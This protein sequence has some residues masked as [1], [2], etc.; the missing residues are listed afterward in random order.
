MHATDNVSEFELSPCTCDEASVVQILRTP[1]HFAAQNGNHEL[2]Q[3]LLQ[4][5]AD[6][7]AVDQANASEIVSSVLTIIVWY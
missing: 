3:L 4:R 2:L 5:G 7:N 6:P 1:L